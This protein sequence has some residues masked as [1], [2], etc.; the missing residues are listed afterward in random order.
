MLHSHRPYLYNM[1]EGGY[2]GIVL[3]TP[4]RRKIGTVEGTSLD[5]LNVADEL[6]NEDPISTGTSLP[7]SGETTD[8]YR[9]STHPSS[10]AQSIRNGLNARCSPARATEAVDLAESSG[11][12][13]NICFGMVR[14]YL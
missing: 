5:N 6:K 13:Q 2:N 1:D 10:W 14:Y 4:K 12:P 9:A 11:E 3:P 7:D 8:D